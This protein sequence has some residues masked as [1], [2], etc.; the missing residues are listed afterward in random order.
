MH[1][2]IF[3]LSVLGWGLSHCNGVI[4]F[5]KAGSQNPGLLPLTIKQISQASQKSSD[6]NFYVD[7][8]DVNNVI[9]ESA[10]CSLLP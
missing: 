7:G 3:F 5:Q 6:D 4:C 8:V 1:T 10:P 2:C 9:L